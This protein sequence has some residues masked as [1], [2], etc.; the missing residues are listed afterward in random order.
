MLI[1]EPEAHLHPQLQIR[2]IKYL[3]TLSS[4]L[5]NAQIIISTHSPVLASSVALKKLIHISGSEEN[6]CATTLSRRV[7]ATEDSE[8]QD[9]AQKKCREEN[10]NSHNRNDNIDTTELFINRWLDVTKSTMLFSRGIIL[11]EGIAECLILPKLAKY[12]LK[13]WNKKHEAKRRLPESLDEMGVSVININGINFTVPTSYDVIFEN[14][15][16]MD[17]KH[18]KDKLKISVV[19]NGTVKKVKENK[20]RNITSGKT[21]FGAA[22]GYLV[23]KNGTYTFSYKQDDKLVVIKSKNMP[24]MIGAMETL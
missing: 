18:D 6:I 17:F 8:E 14:G 4:S 12:V 19:E 24:L 9:I 16:E 21:M 22:E 23:D 15:T 7:F 20:T 11:V 13:K 5:T 1:E 10:T 3:E 2:F